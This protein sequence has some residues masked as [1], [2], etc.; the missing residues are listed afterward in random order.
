MRELF[1]RYGWLTFVGALVANRDMCLGGG[2]PPAR[3]PVIDDGGRDSASSG[4][5]AR[6]RHVRGVGRTVLV[7]AREKV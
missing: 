3:D 4:T 1:L 5:D 6:L 7:V 2:K